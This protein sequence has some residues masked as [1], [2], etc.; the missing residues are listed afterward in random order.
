MNNLSPSKSCC[1]LRLCYATGP[2]VSYSPFSFN[3][4]SAYSVNRYAVTSQEQSQ[5][6]LATSPLVYI[7]KYYTFSR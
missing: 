1:Q 2:L 6:V 4:D 3:I 5:Y 7:F